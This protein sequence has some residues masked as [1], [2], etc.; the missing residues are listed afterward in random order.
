MS[1]VQVLPAV[2][3]AG[4]M[5]AH[6]PFVHWPLQHSPADVQAEPSTTHAVE[7]QT[8]PT[9][10]RLQHSVEVE[11]LAPPGEHLTSEDAHE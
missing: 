4:L 7:P 11:Q 8:P 1:L 2:V 6:L 5:A 3:P 10:A 9:H